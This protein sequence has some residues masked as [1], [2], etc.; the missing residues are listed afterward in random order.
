MLLDK[1]LNKRTFLV[2]QKTTVHISFSFV[3]FRL[4]GPFFFRLIHNVRI[5][6]INLYLK[7]YFDLTY[8]IV[9]MQYPWFR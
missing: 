7:E 3:F 8:A 1:N 2:S 5:P 9:S 6:K 4:E